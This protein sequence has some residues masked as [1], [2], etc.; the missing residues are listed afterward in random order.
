MPDMELVR[1]D[2]R[3]EPE[4]YDRPEEIIRRGESEIMK[5]DVE[6]VRFLSAG[7]GVGRII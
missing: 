4:Y 7:S 3:C 2:T 5:R 1:I 6:W